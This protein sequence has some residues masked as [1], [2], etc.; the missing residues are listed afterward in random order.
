MSLSEPSNLRVSGKKFTRTFRLKFLARNLPGLFGSMVLINRT[1]GLVSD[2]CLTG[3]IGRLFGCAVGLR[4]SGLSGLS[5]LRFFRSYADI[6]E[7]RRTWAAYYVVDEMA[8]SVSLVSAWSDCCS[9]GKSESD[10]GSGFGCAA[11]VGLSG[12]SEFV[13]SLRLELRCS[14]RY[15]VYLNRSGPVYFWRFESCLY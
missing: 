13:V 4:V 14:G 3:L 12:F 2:L 7:S 9:A 5:V 15:L 11:A 8:K 6:P 10:F 1:S